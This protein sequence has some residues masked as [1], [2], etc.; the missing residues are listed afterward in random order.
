[1]GKW[2]TKIKLRDPDAEKPKATHSLRHTFKDALRE[3]GVSRDIANKIQG[4]TAGDAAD[5]YGSSDLLSAKR[6]AASKAWALIM[7]EHFAHKS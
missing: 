6:E 1:L 2:L 5:D 7:G 3:L 4:H